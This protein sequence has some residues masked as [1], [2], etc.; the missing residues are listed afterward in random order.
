MVKEK[1]QLIF[2]TS[3]AN[4]AKNIMALIETGQDPKNMVDELLSKQTIEGKFIVQGWDDYPST[5]AYCILALDL[6]NADYDTQKSVK[7]LIKYQNTDGTFGEY[8]D[9]DTLAMSIMGLSNHKDIEGVNEA[10]QKAVHKLQLEKNNII[11]NDNANTLATVIQGLVSVGENPLQSQW[12]VDQKTMLNAMLKYQNEGNFGNDLATEQV[13]A[14][15]SD[16]YQK[17]SMYTKQSISTEGFEDYFISTKNDGSGSGGGS[18]EQGDEAFISIKG[19]NN[20]PNISKT[21]IKLQKG[22]T[23]LSVTKRILKDKNISYVLNEQKSYFKRIGKYGEFDQ[24]AK[25]GWEY[26]LNGEKVQKSVDDCSVKNKDEIEWIYTT[27]YTKSSSANT[28]EDEITKEIDKIQDILNNTNINEGDIKKAVKNVI[29]QLNKKAEDIKTEADAKNLVSYGKEIS[30]SIQNATEKIKSEETAKNLLKENVRILNILAKSTEKLSKEENQKEVSEVVSKNIYNTLKLIN[31]VN[32]P[33]EVVSLAGNIIDESGKVLKVIGK[34]NGEEIAKSIIDMA[35]STINK[36]SIIQVKKIEDESE[37]SVA[38]LDEN[39]IKETAKNIENTT[40]EIKKK[41]NKNGIEANLIE[42]K[43]MIQIPSISKKE[44]ETILPANTIKILKENNIEKVIIK[45]EKAVFT[46]TSTT[47][48]EVKDNIIL[49]VKEIE[50]NTWT[51]LIPKESIVVDLTAHIGEKSIKECKEKIKVSIPYNG[52]FKTGEI[53]QV[54]Y[55]KDNG[56]IE[57]MG[58]EYDLDTNMV[59]FE[60]SH[61]SKY[62]AQKVENGEEIGFHDLKDYE[63]AKEAIEEMAQKGIINGRSKDV[64]DPSAS[65]TRAEFVTFITKMLGLN[66]ED[67]NISFTD[68]ED[69]AWYTPYVETAYK[70]GLISGKSEAVFD[71]NGKITREEMAVIIGKVL[72]QKGYTKESLEELERFSDKANIA[73]WAN[74]DVALCVKESIISGMTDKTFIPKE[75]AN[76]AQAAIMLYKL[77]HL[78]VE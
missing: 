4:Y 47:F 51:F 8:R 53:V 9:I 29:D 69:S 20:D 28:E 21:K 38:Q 63:W 17:Q 25:S 26:K 65:I 77:Y 68:V 43:M 71:P 50:K 76:R 14:A 60:T 41:L 30:N 22:D 36:W 1:Y 49:K 2:N 35:Q 19:Y 64:F 52:E 46:L 73:P 75:N 6:S 16:L 66:I 31:K 23:V 56:T 42:N 15:L 72:I 12:R 67:I 3:A 11:N 58:G 13:F 59:T 27:D 55:L 7:S 40:K 45:T 5:Q 78:V 33:K 57:N 39:I 70:N 62:F 48:D 32:D 34:E 74:E 18:I 10:I 44:V 37:K 54:F 24:G 61:F